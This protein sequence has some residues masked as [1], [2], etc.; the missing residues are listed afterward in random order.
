MINIKTVC[1][2]T[3]GDNIKYKTASIE[4]I[5]GILM[6]MSVL[7]KHDY[8]HKLITLRQRK[9]YGI[10]VS[11]KEMQFLNDKGKNLQ[12]TKSFIK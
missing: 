1:A 6:T 2:D 11:M 5:F 3:A 10:I 4:E 9:L 12:Y 7:N 8:K